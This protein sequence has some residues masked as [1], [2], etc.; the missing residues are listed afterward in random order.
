MFSSSCFF[1]PDTCCKSKR[2]L[3]TLCCRYVTETC[4]YKVETQQLYRRLLEHASA[5]AELCKPMALLELLEVVPGVLHGN[6]PN[7]SEKR[8]ERER[9][10]KHNDTQPTSH[11]SCNKKRNLPAGCCLVAPENR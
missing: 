11:A 8:G 5:P 2:L 6:K 9:R 1:Y 4:F 3:T 10:N 7:V